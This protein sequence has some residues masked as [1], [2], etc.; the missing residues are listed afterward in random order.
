MV[1]E[2]F[3]K[4]LAVRQ[5]EISR[6]HKNGKKFPNMKYTETENLSFANQG[7]VTCGLGYTMKNCR[8]ATFLVNEA[9]KR[10]IE[11]TTNLFLQRHSLL[12]KKSR[13]KDCL[14]N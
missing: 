3:C 2:N 12:T 13:R 4:A 10:L 9:Q 6:C 1:Q 8:N 7:N 5:P 11:N 14:K